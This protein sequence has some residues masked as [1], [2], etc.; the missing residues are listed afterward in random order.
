MGKNEE[1]LKIWYSMTRE[2]RDY[3]RFVA[4]RIPYGASWIPETANGR[5][6]RDE[7]TD[8]DNENRGCS[9]MYCAPCSFCVEKGEK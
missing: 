9:C 3:D 5:V 4:R 2:Q 1:K 6:M 8:D 7:M